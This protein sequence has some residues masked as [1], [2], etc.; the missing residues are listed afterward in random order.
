MDKRIKGNPRFVLGAEDFTEAVPYFEAK[1]Y[2]LKA[3]HFSADEDEFDL[4]WC[5][6]DSK[7]EVQGEIRFLGKYGDEPFI[8]TAFNIVPEYSSRED[9]VPLLEN[10][11]AYI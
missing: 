7:E 2:R 11:L 5:L 3:D 9:L 1:D 6:L 8:Q 10:S 4:I